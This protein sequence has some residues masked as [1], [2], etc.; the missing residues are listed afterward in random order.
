MSPR[1]TFEFS[2]ICFPPARPGGGPPLGHGWSRAGHD[3]AARA[4]SRPVTP[5]HVAAGRVTAVTAVTAPSRRAGGPFLAT[6]ESLGHDTLACATNVAFA[7]CGASRNARSSRPPP[8]RLRARRCSR[9]FAA[10]QRSRRRSKMSQGQ[11]GPAAGQCLPRRLRRQDRALAAARRLGS[12]LPIASTEPVRPSPTSWPVHV[13]PR[14]EARAWVGIG[15][16]DSVAR[17]RA[18]GRA[19]AR[20]GGGMLLQA[21]VSGLPNGVLVRR[22]PAYRLGWLDGMGAQGFG[23]GGSGALM[24]GGL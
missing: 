23:R 2:F 4:R 6:L 17:W 20:S 24:A 14:A 12:K 9:D 18:L 10:T 11:H 1:L 15:P 21:G 22:D 3:G 8:P 7:L 19:R 5:S 16:A 13:A